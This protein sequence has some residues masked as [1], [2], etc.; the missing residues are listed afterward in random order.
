MEERYF[1]MKDKKSTIYVIIRLWKQ[2]MIFPIGLLLDV[3]AYLA[4][5]VTSKAVD[6][7]SEEL[8]GM[9]DLL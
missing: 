9:E 5:W 2:P 6:F 8:I 1:A 7:L 4:H 3:A